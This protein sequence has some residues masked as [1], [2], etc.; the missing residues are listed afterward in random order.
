[1]LQKAHKYIL[2]CTIGVDKSEEAI[3]RE[4]FKKFYVPSSSEIFDNWA[5]YLELTSPLIYATF[6]RYV[7]KH[8]GTIDDMLN[9]IL[10]YIVENNNMYISGK[11]AYIIF[12]KESK[13]F[14]QLNKK[15]RKY[16]ENE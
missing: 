4:I 13:L 15:I 8:E 12:D 3:K 7:R 10:L 6:D 14:L 5:G 9:F 16:I 1:M 11:Y 2:Q